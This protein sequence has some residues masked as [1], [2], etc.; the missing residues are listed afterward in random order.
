MCPSYPAEKIKDSGKNWWKK[1][2]ILEVLII[3]GCFLHTKSKV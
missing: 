3:F 1:T 2:D